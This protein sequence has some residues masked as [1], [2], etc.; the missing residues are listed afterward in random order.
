MKLRNGFVS[1]SSSSSFLITLPQDITKYTL[2]EFRELLN[3]E[4][5][6]DPI[7]QLYNDLCDKANSQPNLDDWQKRRYGINE[8]DYNQYIVEYGN[9]CAGFG[10]NLT[11]N[12]QYE[13]EELC[14]EI[15]NDSDGEVNV[16]VY[17]NH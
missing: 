6:F 16:R 15:Q 4:G 11:C 2:E 1:N 17:D 9:E 13:M 5:V 8:L 10:N 14:G 12:Q 3:G 7:E